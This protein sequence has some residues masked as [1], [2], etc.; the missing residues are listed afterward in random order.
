MQKSFRIYTLCTLSII[1]VEKSNENHGEN[2]FFVCRIT[3]FPAYIYKLLIYISFQYEKIRN[4]STHP[5]IHKGSASK[6]SSQER[7][8]IVE[9][10]PSANDDIKPFPPRSFVSHLGVGVST[11]SAEECQQMIS[12][13]DKLSSIFKQRRVDIFS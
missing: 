3:P 7:C 6:S 10:R 8:V 9:E 5:P 2:E 12:T 1:S 4:T 13:A 11:H